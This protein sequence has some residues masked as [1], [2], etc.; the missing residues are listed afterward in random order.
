M[1]PQTSSTALAA[2]QSG[3]A[4]IARFLADQFVGNGVDS[5]ECEPI[6]DREFKMLMAL[7]VVAAVAFGCIVNGGLL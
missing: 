7:V 3:K 1:T 4:G 2:E 6:S 5:E